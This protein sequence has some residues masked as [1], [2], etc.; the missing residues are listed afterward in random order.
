MYVKLVR[1]PD[2]VGAGYGDLI[3]QFEA[4][5]GEAGLTHIYEGAPDVAAKIEA[6]RKLI[7]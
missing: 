4:T 3:D 7:Q 6:W 1:G 5:A 2:Y